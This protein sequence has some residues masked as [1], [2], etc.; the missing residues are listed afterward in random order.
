YLGE[1]GR[2]GGRNGQF[3]TPIGVH[4]TSTGM[5][6]VAD[7]FNHRIQYFTAAGSFLGKFGWSGYR[8]GEFN[9]AIDVDLSPSE[10]RVYVTDHNNYRVQYF[11]QRNFAVVPSSLGRVKALVK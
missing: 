6:F 4:I 3:D 11:D 5:V 2:V 9:E 1:W 8:P 7:T 10:T